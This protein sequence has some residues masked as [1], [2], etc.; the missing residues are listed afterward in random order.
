MDYYFDLSETNYGQ[1]TLR[2]LL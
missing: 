1:R 2:I